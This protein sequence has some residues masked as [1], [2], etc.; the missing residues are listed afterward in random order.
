MIHA[1]D[2]N[3]NYLK[4]AIK[5]LDPRTGLDLYQADNLIV[6][7]TRYLFARLFEAAGTTDAPI[8][9]VWGLMLGSGLDSWVDANAGNVATVNINQMTTEILRKP[10]SKVQYVTKTT[11]PDGSFTITPASTNTATVEFQTPINATTD[12]LYDPNTLTTKKIREMGLIGGGQV[13]AATDPTIPNGPMWSPTNNVSNCMTLINY[14]ALP[15]LILPP[16]VTF[17]ISWTLSF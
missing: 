1:F 6:T 14:K 11:A 13:A 3:D 10:Y 16:D 12:G 5:I 7:G 2:Q 17:L 8:W 4:G 15:T 9:P